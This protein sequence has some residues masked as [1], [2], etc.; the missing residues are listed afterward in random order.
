MGCRLLARFLSWLVSYLVLLIVD[1]ET[2][3]E[4]LKKAN[5]GGMA[6]ERERA[7]RIGSE[8]RARELEEELRRLRGREVCSQTPVIQH[9]S[10]VR[11]FARHH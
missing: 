10:S 11:Q 9:Q 2:G 4:Q 5:P 3:I 6:R 8:N 7:A 1:S